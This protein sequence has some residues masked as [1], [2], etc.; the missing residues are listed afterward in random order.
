MRALKSPAMFR[1]L[2]ESVQTSDEEFTILQF[3][4]QTHSLSVHSSYNHM[5]HSLVCV[6]TFPHLHKSK[7]RLNIKQY[8]EMKI[9]QTQY[10][11]KFSDKLF[12]FFFFN[13]ICAPDSHLQIQHIESI[14]SEQAVKCLF[15]MYCI[16]SLFQV[17]LRPS[18]WIHLNVHK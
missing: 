5:L 12:F 16:E 17:C 1:S 8:C 7:V 6:S 10:S 18:N 14:L 3:N 9:R 2:L 11:M 4:S 15:L 13:Q